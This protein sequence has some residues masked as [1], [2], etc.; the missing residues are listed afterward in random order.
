MNASQIE[1][2][3]IMFKDYWSSGNAKNDKKTNWQSTFRNWVRKQK[4]WQVNNIHELIL[5]YTYK[6]N[7]LLGGFHLQIIK[8]IIL[9]LGF[10]GL[11]KLLRSKKYQKTTVLLPFADQRP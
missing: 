1:K 4:P 9:S 5:D 7:F 3:V 6:Q 8:I 11:I 10:L 2:N